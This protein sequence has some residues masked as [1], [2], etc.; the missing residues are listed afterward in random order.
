MIIDLTNFPSPF[1]S[2]SKEYDITPEILE[3]AYR[4]GYLWRE[5]DTEELLEY[6]Q[7]LAGIKLEKRIVKR[8]IRHADTNEYILT[9][10]KK[11]MKECELD[12]LE[13]KSYIKRLVKDKI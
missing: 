13:D 11:G 7:I 5:Y 3:K 10:Q 4:T 6:I 8:F 2:Y 9:L 1:E 12:K